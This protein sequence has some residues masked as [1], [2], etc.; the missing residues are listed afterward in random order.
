MAK[1]HNPWETVEWVVKIAAQV[2][3]LIVELRGHRW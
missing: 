2:I 1:P 3:R